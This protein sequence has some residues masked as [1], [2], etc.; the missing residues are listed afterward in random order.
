[1]IV[2]IVVF[3]RLDIFVDIFW[4]INWFEIVKFD[5]KFVEVVVFKFVNYIL[6]YLEFVEMELYFNDIVL[7]KRLKLVNYI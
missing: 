7:F 2:I 6:I 4:V 1:M 3:L 5:N